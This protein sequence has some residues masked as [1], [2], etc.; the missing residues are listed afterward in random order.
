MNA[1]VEMPIMVVLLQVI[2]VI[3]NMCLVDIFTKGNTKATYII[4]VMLSHNYA[5]AGDN[6]RGAMFLTWDEESLYVNWDKCPKIFNDGIE[7][8]TSN[9]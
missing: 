4:L 5:D 3:L 6:E 9:S 1:M 7:R 8:F 2:L